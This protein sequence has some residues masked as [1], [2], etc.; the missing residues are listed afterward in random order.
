MAIAEWVQLSGA[1]LVLV[2]F[3]LGQLERI[4]AASWTYL[5]LNAVGSG[6]LAATAVL[7]AQWGFLLLEG[8]W[9]LVSLYGIVQKL[10][11]ATPA[12]PH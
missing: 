12:A 9:A 7:A 1:F 3:V 5:M 11:G 8:S 10:R 4:A 6:L 2:A